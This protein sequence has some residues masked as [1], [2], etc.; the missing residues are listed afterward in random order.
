M[1]S[2]S[3]SDKPQPAPAPRIIE[4]FNAFALVGVTSFGGGLSGRMLHE[5][6]GRRGW[7][8]ER[9]FFDGLALSQALPGV[10]VT[11]LAIWIE[12]RLGAWRDATAGFLGIVVPSP[13]AIV[14][15]GAF[16]T[17]LVRFHVTHVARSAI[18]RDDW[19]RY[20]HRGRC[21]TPGG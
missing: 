17:A 21:A 6:G 20:C 18:L 4:I 13:I 14:L 7:I 15:L 1:Q 11:D 8:A 19:R 16:F 3:L 12:F 5:F 9:E 10:N 2:S